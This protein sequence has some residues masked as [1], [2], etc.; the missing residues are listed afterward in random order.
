MAAIL[1][2]IGTGKEQPTIIDDL[3]DLNKCPHKPNYT[4][5]VEYPLILE[6][7]RYDNISFDVH[8]NDAVSF[9]NTFNDIVMREVIELTL[10]VNCM[11]VMK[12]WLHESKGITS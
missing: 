1:F 5:A 6:D 7:C 2:L 12:I 3:F 11:H 9:Y 10:Y 8:K 4:P